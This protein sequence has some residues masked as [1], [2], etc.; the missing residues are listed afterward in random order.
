M[1]NKLVGKLTD[2]GSFQNFLRMEP[3][4]FDEIL[5][6]VKPL[7]SNQDTIMRSAISAHDKL[8]IT[9]RFLA[10]GASYK[11]LMYSF[12]VSTASI[13]KFVP[14]VCQ[15]IYDVVHEDYLSAPSSTQWPEAPPNSGSEDFSYKKQFSIVLLAIADANAKFTAFDLG[16]AG[17]QS[18][19]GVFKNGSLGNICKTHNFPAPGHFDQRMLDVPCYLLGDEA[20]ALDEHLMKPYPYRSAMGDQKVFNYGLSRA[21]IVENAFGILCE[22]F[23][24]LLRTLELDVTSAMQVVRACIT[25]HNFLLTKKEQSYSSPGMM[26]SEDEQAHLVPGFW[27][28]LTD[29][30]DLCNFRGDA[31]S[32]ASISAFTVHLC[33]FGQLF[34]MS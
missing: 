5:E 4:F 30:Q 15:A 26:D 32:R 10:S 17:S 33:T 27:R 20:F 21:R 8:C 2:P 13:S 16:A 12:R 34:G 14:E 28:G 31:G 23:R 25:L 22:R 1:A 3:C 24:V 18:D 6:K 11:D 19:G 9:M 7:I 29:T